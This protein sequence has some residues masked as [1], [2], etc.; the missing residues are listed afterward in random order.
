MNRMLANKET[1]NLKSVIT[2][3]WG[4][5]HR[6]AIDLEA[7]SNA[8]DWKLGIDL[9]DNYRIDQI[10]GA[11]LTQEGDKIYISGASWNKYLSQGSKTEI[12][13]IIDEGNSG[14]LPP[15]DTQFIYANSND[16]FVEQDQSQS[17]PIINTDSQITQD[18]EGG[19]KL[20]L[21]I[22]AE[23]EANNWQIDFNLPY[24]IREVYGVDLTDNGNGNYTI[25]GQNDQVNLQSGQSIKP[26]FIIDDYGQSAL[27]L[28]VTNF[29]AAMPEAPP[30][31]MEPI[32][33]PA[34]VEPE[35][36]RKMIVSPSITEDW[37]G[38]YK[39]E[40]A[41]EAESEANNWQV[42]FNLPYEIREV[43]G[44]DLI[45]QGNGNYTIMGQNDQVNLQQGQSIKPI[46][47]VDDY[48]QQALNPQF[49]DSVA[50]VEPEP[51][52]A[53]P[54]VVNPEPAA[55][56]N[57]PE[58]QAQSV[59][60]NGQFSYGEALQKNFLFFEANRSGALGP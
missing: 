8:E 12:I 60:Q 53:S 18:W 17:S 57:I 2:D 56:V 13:L 28:N 36:D 58:T 26:I 55:P 30:E 29:S 21:A 3:D 23:S 46:F 24:S 32:S 22:E 51:E 50:F 5:S 49:D 33:A 39:L 54:V 59:G 52:P 47:I 20:E 16:N 48:G 31:I 6:I 4:G 11:E 25:K 35:S 9:P 44:V 15:M 14:S 7:L 10:Y 27:E 34:P 42:N 1:F 40:L 37:E 19:Y 38:G 45:D 41:I 43:Y